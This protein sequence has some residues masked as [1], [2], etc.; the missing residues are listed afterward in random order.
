MTIITSSTLIA[1]PP[2]L[3][4]ATFLDWP[5]LTLWDKHY[6][7]TLTPLLPNGSPDP[8]KTTGLSVVPGDKVHGTF[9]GGEAFLDILE[10]G[11][12]RLRWRGMRRERERGK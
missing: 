11:E 8:S 9:W 1:A 2:S 4:R 12:G 3:V 5:S 10:N 7:K 6:M